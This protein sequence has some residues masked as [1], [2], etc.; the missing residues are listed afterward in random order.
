MSYAPSDDGGAAFRI[1]LPGG[2]RP[3]AEVE[4]PTVEPGQLRILVVD[5]E[6]HIIH[7]MRATLEAWGHTVAVASNGTEALAQ[8]TAQPFDV[9][10][11]DLRMPELGGRELYEALEQEHP[12]I[13]R[14][15]VFSTG[16][17]VGGDT[18]RFLETAGRPFLRKPFTLAELRSA[19][20][21]ATTAS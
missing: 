2:G 15:V 1:E 16:D 5:D 7:Y 17:T 9:V 13:A 8:A 19:L 12:A 3:A 20:A 11:T 18:L 14:C 6:P 21:N 4:E 10:I